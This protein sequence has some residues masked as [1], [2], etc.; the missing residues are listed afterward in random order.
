MKVALDFFPILLFFAAYKFADIY[1]ATAVLMAAT[2]LQM[3]AM[4]AIDRKL[5]TMHKL[6]LVLVLGFGALTL[7]LHDERFIKWKPTVLYAGLALALAVAL[8]GLRKNF[9]KLLLGQPAQP[10]RRGV[11]PAQRRLGALL[12]LHGQHQRR[13]RGVLQHRNL[14]ELQTLGLCL[15]AGVHPRAGGVHLAPPRGR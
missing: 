2:V 10:A 11:A 1:I 15:S 12:R 6:T 4:Y 7:A 5:T 8:W 3:G 9:L 13:R 14:G